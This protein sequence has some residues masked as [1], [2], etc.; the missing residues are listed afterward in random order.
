MKGSAHRI[1]RAARP[2][3]FTLIELLV[4]IAI[5]AVL[6]SLLLPAL[7]HAKESGRRVKCLS[8]VRQ[9]QVAW[10]M[11][12]DDHDD[13][14]PSNR[15]YG[16]P[17]HGWT[18][19]DAQ[20]ERTTA[21]ILSGTLYPYVSATAVYR[22]PSDRSQVPGTRVLKARSYSLNDWLNGWAPFPPAAPVGRLNQ[23][24]TPPPA[25]VFA[26]L[27]EHEESID[28]GALGVYP[29]GNWIWW[30]LPASRHRQGC[31]LSFADGHVEYWRWKDESVLRFVS[32]W[33]P[34]PEGDR[35][36]KRIQGAIPEASN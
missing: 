7:N 19:D 33:Q 23:L 4:V 14:L 5:I 3:A 1:G 12:A 21:K 32:Y 6:A 15:D 10:L 28:N 31:V 26:F 18:D 2:L 30:N 22:C 25:G 35:D 29:P 9:L 27:D 24:T 17:D 13:R 11:Y 34:A 36:L 16:Q 8:N 20:V